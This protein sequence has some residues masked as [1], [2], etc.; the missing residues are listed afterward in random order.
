MRFHLTPASNNSKTGPIVVSTTS[1]DTCPNSCELKES[2]CYAKVGTLGMHWRAVDNGKRGVEWDRFLHQIQAIEP[3]RLFRHNQAGDLPGDGETIN[4]HMCE[5]LARASSH[6]KAFT[7]T[8]Y[9]P[10]NAVNAKAIK[11]MNE[12][13]FTVNLSAKSLGDAD[14]LKALGIGPVVVVVTSDTKENIKTPQ[15]NSVVIC[16][17][18]IKD[19]ITCLDCK[20][21]ANNSETRPI[22][23]F[24]AHGTSKK[25]MD[26]AIMLKAI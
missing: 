19:D 6:L 3:N 1:S 14:K 2:G 15:G 7:Y 23:G 25:K 5:Q 11:E 13:G 20:L 10:E 8:H 24:P 26:K 17:A 21:C 16:P 22:V 4:I 18:T 12:A 9:R